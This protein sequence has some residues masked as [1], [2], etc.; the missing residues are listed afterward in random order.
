M[1]N[2]VQIRV[3][4]WGARGSNPMLQAV[5]PSLTLKTNKRASE[6]VYGVWKNNIK[7]KPNKLYAVARSYPI[8]RVVS[9]ATP[10]LKL[11]SER[12]S[13]QKG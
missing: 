3:E 6:R 8:E 12:A 13:E 7:L 10:Y 1:Y 5:A 9:K 11:T 4:L 2:F